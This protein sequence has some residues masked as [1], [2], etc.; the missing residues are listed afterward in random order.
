MNSLIRKRSNHSTT[1]IGVKVDHRT[2]KVAFLLVNDE[3]SLVISSIELGRIFRGD[4]H[5]NRKILMLGK[6]PHETLFPCDIVRI[7]SLMIY[8]DIVEYNIVGD[9]KHP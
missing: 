9:K 8:S 7:H 3:S 5:N 4:V 1:W 6:G 2:Q